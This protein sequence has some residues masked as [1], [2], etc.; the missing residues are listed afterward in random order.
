LAK[1]L[2]NLL[3]LIKLK[4]NSTGDISLQQNELDTLTFS[5]IPSALENALLSDSL[6]NKIQE[7][8]ASANRTHLCVEK[9]VI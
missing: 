6:T 9:N 8:F 7:F 2:L 5:K 4:K 1:K 3:Y